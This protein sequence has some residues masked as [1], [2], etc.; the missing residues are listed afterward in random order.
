MSSKSR[1]IQGPVCGCSPPT[2]SMSASAGGASNRTK[3]GVPIWD[4]EAGTFNDF[5]EACLM[6]E[7]SVAKEKRYLCGPKIVAELTGAA[8]RLVTGKGPT[9]ISYNGG[10]QELLRHLRACLGKPQISELSEFLNKYF[11]H[12]RRRPQETINDYVTRKCEVYLRA[13]QALRRV[14]PHHAAPRPGLTA[15]TSS[16][17]REPWW[18]LSP[19]QHRLHRLQPHRGPVRHSECRA[20]RSDQ[21]GAG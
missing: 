11:K 18:T 10:V 13:Q 1:T 21:R 9:W 15:R 20:N 7:Q 4:G 6:Y 3:D 2:D 17:N 16:D 14:A 12:S 5:E 8:R 19:E